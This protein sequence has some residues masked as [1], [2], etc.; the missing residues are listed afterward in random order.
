MA[1][2]LLLDVGVAATAMMPNGNHSTSHLGIV[3]LPVASSA[4]SSQTSFLSVGSTVVDGLPNMD[5]KD[6][7][8][9]LEI[10]QGQLLKE[11]NVKNGAE[12]MLDTNPND[13]LR[14]R[15]EETLGQ[16]NRRIAL[17]TK[18]IEE[19]REQSA[20]SRTVRKI[21]SAQNIG[22]AGP[23]GISNSRGYNPGLAS[24]PSREE[25]TANHEDYRTAI[26]QAAS[27]TSTLVSYARSGS[28][29]NSAFTASTSM[30]SL[31]L[32]N[33][34]DPS[35]DHIRAEAMDKL[36]Q[37]LQSNVRVAYELDLD[38]LLPAIQPC[39]ADAAVKETRAG[40]YRL[41]CHLVVGADVT[42]RL[43]TF[44]IDYYIVRSLARDSKH[45]VEKEH[46]IRL[47]RTMV[48]VGRLSSSGSPAGEAV[49]RALVSIAEHVEDPFRLASIE[50][51][52][53]IMLL[54]VDLVSRTGGMRVLLGVL[55]EGPEEM[56][57]TLATTFLYLLDMPATRGY[58]NPGTDLEIA[59][60][61]ITDAYGKGEA[62]LDRMHACAKV[63]SAILRTWSGLMYLCMDNMQ[64]IRALVDTL[65]IPS[66]TTRDVVLDLFFD[67]LHIKLPEWHAA[68]INGRRLTMYG[69]QKPLSSQPLDPT[70]DD[71][72]QE[73]G[74]LNLIDQYIALLLLVFTQAGL[75]EALVTVLEET[76][77][78]SKIARKATLL[79]G[80]VLQLANRVLP[81]SMAARIQTLTRVFNLATD[82][83][84]GHNRI[85]GTS[86]LSSRANSV[87]EPAR[88]GQ[89]SAEQ[90]VKV[91][92]GMQIDDRDFQKLILETQVLTAKDHHG[93]KLSALF[94]LVD[95]PLL[96]PK[97][98]EEALKVSKFGRRL[99]T[100]FH[101][102]TLNGFARQKRTKQ[103]LRWVKLG[104]MLMTTLLSNQDGVRF[105]TTDDPMLRQI[106]DAFNEIDPTRGAAK[107]MEEHLS[108]GYLEMLGT[109]S[110]Y[111]DG[112]DLLE[113]LKFFT[114]FYHLSELRS[115]EDLTRAI[116]ENIDYSQDGHPRILLS[117]ALTSSYQHSRV[118]ATRHLGVLI[119]NSTRASSWMLR[120]LL[121]Q[122]YDPAPEVCELAVQYLRQACED[123]EVLQLVVEM[124]PTLDHL[125]DIGHPLL[126]KFM[127]TPIGF[128][129]LCDAGY[130]VQEMEG[131]FHERN[132]QYAVQ[133]EIYLARAFNLAESDEDDEQ[134]T[135]EGTVPAHFYGEMA[136]TEL[137][138]QVLLEKG[139]FNEF[140]DF[141]RL[142]GQESED[143]EIIEKL[144]SVLWAVGNIAATPRGLQF[145]EDQQI[146]PNILEIA[147]QSLVLSVRGT[148]FF[149]LGLISSTPQGAETLDDYG[150][151][152]TMSPL[153]EPTGLC[154]PSTLERFLT[155]PP[156][157][158]PRE[159]ETSAGLPPLP[160][161]AERDALNC[162][163]NLSN[164]VIAN[165]SS[166]TLAKL[167]SRPETRDVFSSLRLFDRALQALSTQRYRQPVRRYIFEL[168]DVRLDSIVVQSL[169][170]HR[171]T[172]ILG[173]KPGASNRSKT[174][175]LPNARLRRTRRG[176]GSS[177]SDS[178]DDYIAS[179]TEREIK[180]MKLRPAQ[181]IVGGFEISDDEDDSDGLMA[182]QT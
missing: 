164:T 10:L 143:V 87:D 36:V 159:H 176:S 160:T 58:L 149:V 73:V 117:K 63:V 8:Q 41:L 99:M 123:R 19:L 90:S 12:N 167:K 146:I 103:N 22:V 165:A 57:P 79:I 34:E 105:L 89:R 67:L 83:Q 69:R 64:A 82:Y 49:M 26:A 47:I 101:P 29:A 76:T 110:R 62:H 43:R 132:K 174:P 39:L 77:S 154:V 127:S 38:E 157:Y 131:W 4:M 136:K 56:A 144:K 6:V 151:E 94:D 52:A 180:P 179:E 134:L 9:Q 163:Y 7:V 18:R 11:R 108:Y 133:V 116:I 88:R 119:Q 141:I 142:H 106:M 111:Q 138:C 102:A 181:V 169:Q 55:A 85:V 59:L 175:G 33:I 65:R 28:T 171:R 148:C 162:I 45:A 72:A 68:F 91:K 156:C 50:T 15:I 54:D 80:E 30:T 92:M 96:N 170:E 161:Q 32:S 48:E 74:R 124:Q 115:R 130:I 173:A 17:L 128:Q 145:L 46:A 104:C 35:L 75:V 21:R 113:K 93:W 139:H 27:C 122:L 158:A 140:A 150:W 95:G 24:K 112:V 129:Y 121:T 182:S 100:F 78:G 125:G 37:A 152:A 109:M 71:S 97:R 137:G 14:T 60:S 3:T 114:S 53:E 153:G 66:L 1:G 166:R 44:G 107:Y 31:A 147:E 61:G 177:E 51:L 178:E 84:D 13:A 155:L 135:F 2:P 172:T 25:L 70:G 23:S 16:A 168:F 20:P 86:A 118:F 81:L 5:G 40:A 98:L 42:G 126:L 120:L